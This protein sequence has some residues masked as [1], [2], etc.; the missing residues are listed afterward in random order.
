MANPKTQNPLYFFSR[1]RPEEQDELILE[2]VLALAKKG[3][4]EAGRYIASHPRA[5]VAV[6]WIMAAR[7]DEDEGGEQWVQMSFSLGIPQN[8]PLGDWIDGIPFDIQIDSINRRIVWES[9]GQLC[10]PTPADKLLPILL[11]N[12]IKTPR[13]LVEQPYGASVYL[14]DNDCKETM[15]SLVEFIEKLK[16]WNQWEP[17]K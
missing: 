17:T 10:D 2:R 4:D 11:G 5:E 9:W 1:L 15:M 14:V 16:T 3:N 8:D 6:E 12:W 13:L 7:S